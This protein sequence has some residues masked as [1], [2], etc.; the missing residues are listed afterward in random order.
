MI[1][2]NQDYIKYRLE[3]AEES[4]SEAKILTE[5]NHWNAIANRLYYACF[6]AVNALLLKYDINTKTHSGTKSKFHEFIHNT[7]RL[8]LEFGV[9][10][11]NLFDLRH[12]GDYED[13]M[14][15]TKEKVEPLIR[16]TERFIESI[17]KIIKANDS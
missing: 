2:S 3:R 14:I 13:M 7:K 8:E 5:G 12:S 6:Y 16:E 1:F 17:K 9:L 4:L 15:L 11:S 10:Y